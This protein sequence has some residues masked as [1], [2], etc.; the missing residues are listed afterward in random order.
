MKEVNDEINQKKSTI[1]RWILTIS[2]TIIALV[3]THIEGQ[4]NPTEIF[5]FTLVIT[6]VA[7]AIGKTAQIIRESRDKAE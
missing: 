6:A 3:G 4:S 2:A 5:H 1:F 7:Y